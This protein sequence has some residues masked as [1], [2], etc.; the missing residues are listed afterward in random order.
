MKLLLIWITLVFAV[1]VSDG[2]RRC[3]PQ[4]TQVDSYTSVVLSAFN[5]DLRVMYQT[6]QQLMDVIQLTDKIDL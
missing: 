4:L 5:Y 3:S 6:S 2:K 1:T